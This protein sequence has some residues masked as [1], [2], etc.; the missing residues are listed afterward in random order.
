[1]ALQFISGN[2]VSDRTGTIYRTICEQSC[3]HPQLRYLFLVPEQA[4]L[5]VQRELV[6]VHPR[7]VLGNIDVLSFGRLAYRLMEEQAGSQAMLLDDTGKSMILRRIAGKEEQGLEVFG[8]SLRQNGFIKELKSIISEF[9]AYR[10]TSQV[11]EELLPSLESRPM[12]QKKLRDIGRIFDAFHRELGDRYITAEDLLSVLAKLVPQSALIRGSIV[13]MDGF[14]GFTPLQYQV[15]EELLQYAR[16]VVCAVTEDEAGGRDELFAM[17][18]ELKQQLTALAGAHQVSCG[19]RNHR[20]IKGQQKKAPEILHLEKQLYRYP[21]QP[22]EEKTEAVQIGRAA[23]PG[24][25]LEFVLRKLLE[26]IRQGYHYRDIAVIAGDLSVYERDAQSLF[27]QAKIPFFIDRKKELK[28][29]PLVQL[30]REALSVLEEQMSYDSVMAFLRNPYVCSEC[31]GAESG[32]LEPGRVDEL[33]NYLLAG[34]IDRLSRWKHPWVMPYDGADEKALTRLN[35]LRSQIYDWFAPLRQVWEAGE[36]TVREAMTALFS[37]LQ[38]FDIPQKLKEQRQLFNSRGEYYLESEYSQ[39]YGKILGLFDQIVELMGEERLESRVLSDILDS[40]FEELQVGFIPAA[41]DR[42]VV[43]DL[44]RTRLEHIK[45]LFVVGAN[46]RLLPRQTERGGILTDYDREILKG[47]GVSLALSAREEAFH[48]QYYLYLLL[49][50]PSDALYLTY[51]ECSS[52]GK[53]LRP[54]HLLTGVKKIFPRCEELSIRECYPGLEGLMQPS[55]GFL[56]MTAGLR[57]YLDGEKELWWQELYDYYMK[58]GGYEERLQSLREALF[59]GYRTEKLDSAIA[60]KLFGEKQELSISRLEKYAACAYA[61]FLTYGLQLRQRKQFELQ[62]ADYGSLFHASISHFFEL[63]EK[64]GLD[65][66]KLEAEQR[67]SLVEESAARAMEEYRT[68][69]FDSSARNQFMAGRICRLTDRTLWALGYQW[70]QGDYEKTWH[71]MDFGRAA[72]NSVVLSVAEGLALSLQGR[73]DRVDFAVGG[74]RIYVKV[75]DYKSGGTKLDLGKVY[76]GLQLQLV[77]YLEAA[78]SMTAKKY[79]GLEMIPAGIYYYNMK[80]PMVEGFGL[81]DEEIAEKQLK[82]LKM[83]G[84]TSTEGDSL[85][86]IDRDGGKVVAGLEY[87]KDGTLSSRALAGSGEEMRRLC[88][89]GRKKAVRLAQELYSGNIDVRPYEYKKQKPCTY[90]EYQAVCGFDI[91]TEGCSYRRL[92]QLDKD[93]VWKLLRE[94][95]KQDQEENHG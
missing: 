88:R 75:I 89:Y 10:V 38:Q 58:D 28:K 49:T 27:T 18:R 92:S 24:E 81:S 51:S 50:R 55:D 65:W 13:I 37:F 19:I 22:W 54:A 6:R 83:N 76:Y 36:V 9:S 64:R 35:E 43:G 7:H 32:S 34:G 71:E 29:H 21:V 82:E 95:E 20:Y 12:L 33:D 94:E 74:D 39:V 41:V 61:H 87:K 70:E 69:V 17:S 59:Y 93:E 40:G 11:L 60:R 1:M 5:Q 15:L 30:I 8:R 42:L 23:S 79:P 52:D 80:D 53:I 67:N 68:A 66:R 16:H 46:D 56:L 2:S 4:T 63:L 25:E 77:L 90:C 86:L 78:L 91:K 14:T 62:A 72:G 3:S 73:I 26:L 85:R 44:M 48:Q 57:R 84:L 45:V 47:E 31:A